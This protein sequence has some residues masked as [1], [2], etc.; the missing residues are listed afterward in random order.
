[1]TAPLDSIAAV[2]RQLIE[3]NGAEAYIAFALGVGAFVEDVAR[4][5]KTDRHQVEEIYEKQ[6]SWFWQQFREIYGLGVELG[7]YDP[8]PEGDTP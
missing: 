4:E 1:M 3:S 7:V 6:Y 5:V 2:A 8:L